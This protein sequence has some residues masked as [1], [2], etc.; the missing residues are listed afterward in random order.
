MIKEI[1][2]DAAG[3]IT[4]TAVS[5]FQDDYGAAVYDVHEVDRPYIDFNAPPGDT[6][7]PVFFQP[8]ADLTTNGLELWVGAKGISDNWGGCM[9]YVS[10]D[11]EHY[12]LTGQITNRA[13]YGPLVANIS[14][15]S[16]SMEVDIDGNMLS[17]TQ[18]DAE[19]GNTLLWVDGECLSYET[20]TL[21]QNGHYLLNGLIR[22]QYNTTP[23]AHNAGSIVVRCDEALLKAPFSKEDIGKQIWLKFC[24][25]NIFGAGEQ[26]L[27]DVTA[28]TYTLQPYYVPPVR[29]LTA[30]NRY[31]QLKDGVNRYDIVVEWDAPILQSY[32]E[33]RVWYK[34]SGGQ[35]KY[36]AMASGVKVSELGFSENWIFAGSGKNTVTIPQAIVGDIYKIAVTTV[37]IWGVETS[38]DVSPQITLTVA[39]KTEAP[40]TPDG[41]GITFGEAAVVSWKEVANTDI[42][43]YEVRFDT[44]P[45]V[46]NAMLLARVTG[47]STS[48]TLTTRTGRLYLYAYSASK[49]YSTPAILDYNK[50]APTTPRAPT[51]SA[52]LE[53]FSVVADPIPAGCIGMNI[54]IDPAGADLQK[55]YSQ[56]NVYGYMCGANVYEVSVAY[57]D[58]FGE[59]SHSNSSVVTV[60]ATVDSS[61]LESGAVS[62]EKCDQAVTNA[63]AD[64]AY[65]KEQIV[66][67]VA[68][69]GE[70]D[71][72]QTAYTSI[73]QLVDAL[74]LRVRSREIISKINMS[75]ETITIDGALIHIT[76][77]TL[78]D[79]DVI[80]NG[81][82]QANAV[83]ADKMLI[84]STSGARLA[85]TNNLLSVYDA[86]GTL[87]VKMGVWEE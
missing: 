5:W 60:K 6:D 26:S 30:R 12:R 77:N 36:L 65:S 32:L 38:P 1:Q 79:N 22:G 72:G 34:T 71:D 78:F 75:P 51:L 17:G 81:M 69:M 39:M 59:G 2:E 33:G 63:L 7:T 66:Q 24:S 35:A 3:F 64:G 56:N 67:L 83:T 14:A 13:R 54:Y 43:Y 46:E 42:A 49:K 57:V 4:V 68:A 73:T 37:D 61:L 45:G 20:A 55:V 41:F 84:G 28:C 70:M 62:L 50:P 40:N 80:T 44:N 82:I 21:L 29:N 10:D 11:D 53:G 87:R 16:T 74:E 31:R 19:R 27:S 86:N 85:L 48:L 25:Y 76:G 8:P 58:L 18:Q 52:K 47:L 9:V 15:N 23:A